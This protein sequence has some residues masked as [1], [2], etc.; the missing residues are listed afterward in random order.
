MRIIKSGVSGELD[1]KRNKIDRSPHSC[2]LITYE[3]R[4]E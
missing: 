2:V 3:I 1:T 4:W